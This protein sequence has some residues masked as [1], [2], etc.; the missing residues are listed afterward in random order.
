[1]K[2][3]AVIGGGAAGLM[4]AACLARAN[5]SVD[6]YEKSDRVGK[7]ILASGNGRCN[8]TNE[9]I[10]VNDYFGTDPQFVRPAIEQ[11]GYNHFKKFC[12]TI[13][14]MIAT[15]NEGKVYPL[16]DDARSVAAAFESAARVA[17]ATIHCNA[18][19]Q[20]LSRTPEGFRL[21]IDGRFT[22]PYEALIIT[23]GSEAAP[24]LGST[25]DGYAFAQTFGHMTAPVYP[26]L[27]ALELDSPYPAKLAG[28]KQKA[29]VT[30][31]LN[32]KPEQKCAGDIL[33]TKY[34]ISG[35]AILDISSYASKALA[36]YQ[37]VSIGVTLMPSFERQSLFSLL[38]QLAAEL[39]HH[40]LE[41]LLGGLIPIKLARVIIQSL[42][43]EP[44]IPANEVSTKL[45][46]KIAN[47]LIDW[48]FNVTQ[49]H[50]FK[51]AEVSGGGV[52]TDDIDPATMMSKR[53]ENLYFAGEVLDIVGRRGGYNLHFAWASGYLAA[54]HIITSHNQAASTN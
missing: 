48:R 1:M 53:S 38:N 24:Q 31:Y 44:S 49:T 21:S 8:I 18:A 13:G 45:L 17:G 41:T 26:S 20:E 11:F 37:Q 43:L 12:R 10:G 5:I 3:V 19:V 2:T 32:G 42:A 52:M 35:F 30:L 6:L 23:T 28:I 34:G 54:Q 15:K 51:H 50:G 40:S 36:E 29:V 7:K 33:F 39:P 4:A 46:R 9:S 22:S 27:V 47:T 25:A 16:S 14:L